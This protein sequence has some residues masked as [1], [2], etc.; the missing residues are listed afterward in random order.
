LRGTALHKTG[1]AAI[2]LQARPVR[3]SAPGLSYAETTS[4][5]PPIPRPSGDFEQIVRAYGPDLYRYAFWLVRD[6][7]VAEELVQ[8]CFARAWTGWDGLRE[9]GALKAWLFTILRNERARYFEKKRPVLSDLSD[10]MQEPAV[11]PALDEGLDIRRRIEQLPVA[12]REPLVLQVLGGYSCGEIAAMMGISEGAVMTRL[13]R[14]RQAL[15]AEA[16]P[17]EARRAARA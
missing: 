1:R 3:K 11:I 12:Y 6:R 5:E 10:E 7:F 14:A 9:A 13:T 16:S 17:V 2:S 4:R 8:E 15:R